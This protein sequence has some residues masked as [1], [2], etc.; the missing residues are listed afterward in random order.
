MAKSRKWQDYEKMVARIYQEL[1]PL[2]TV[3]HD[4]KIIGKESKI[5]RQID[6]SIRAKVAG[7]EILIIVQA[8]DYKK[9]PDIN[10]VGEFALVIK[11]VGASKGILVSNV[12]FTEGARNLARSL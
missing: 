5:E 7:H 11:D 10:V 8:K 1:E 9:R 6:V 4:D 3:T 12:G 2:A